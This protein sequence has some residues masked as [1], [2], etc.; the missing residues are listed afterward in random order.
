MSI[1]VDQDNVKWFCMKY[2]KSFNGNEW[3]SYADEIGYRWARSVAVD[4]NNVK[5]FGAPSGIISFDGVTWTTYEDG[6]GIALTGN[7]IVSIAV[8]S[9][10]VKWFAMNVYHGDE[11]REHKVVS[12]DDEH[13]SVQTIDVKDEPSGKFASWVGVG[14]FSMS[15]DEYDTKWLGTDYGVMKSDGDTWKTFLDHPSVASIAFDNDVIWLGTYGG[16][17]SYDGAA[18]STFLPADGLADRSAP[19]VVVDHDGVK[20]IGTYS[21]IS[22]YDDRSPTIVMS[23]S[24]SAFAITGNHPNPFNPSTTIEFTLDAGASVN[25]DIYSITGQHVKSFTTEFLPAGAHDVIWDGADDEGIDVSSG[26]YYIR[27]QSGIHT[28]VHRMML[29]R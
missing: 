24:S 18:W 12:F 4:R 25:L 6:D 5:W 20:W 10:N 22:R 19:I 26:I 17:L 2:I 29:I 14:I 23:P 27:L 28:S 1:A 21:G 9:H 8:D 11:W 7:E 16:V 15:I 13:W 3:K